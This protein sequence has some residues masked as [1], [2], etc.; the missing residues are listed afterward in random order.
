MP[1]LMR[2]QCG[3]ASSEL[4]IA[5]VAAP[6]RAANV[7]AVEAGVGAKADRLERAR[8]RLDEAGLGDVVDAALGGAP[9]EVVAGERPGPGDAAA[10]REQAEL[11][12][13]HVAHADPARAGLDAPGD[14]LPVDPVEQA[15]Q[16]VAAAAGQRDARARARDAVQRRQAGVVVAGEALHP[17]A[18]RPRRSRPRSR[19][20]RGAPRRAAAAPTERSTPAGE[21]TSRPRAASLIAA[22]CRRSRPT[23]RPGS[24]RPR[25]RCRRQRARRAALPV[26][27]APL[28]EERAQHLAGGLG[29]DAALDDRVVVQRGVAE[30]V[31]HRAGRARLRVARAVDD[32][33]DAR[34]QQRHRAHRA[35]LERHVHLALGQAVVAEQLG[36]VAQGDDLGV[37]GRVVVGDRP[38]VAGRDRPGAR[39]S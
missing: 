6:E 27:L 2:G 30:D 9:A 36:G 39:L 11:Q 21:N 19:A 34:V 7:E 22:P 33:L 18:S 16:A 15:R 13:R 4:T 29:E 31:D 23:R 20:C 3:V 35:R 5:Q 14:A 38:V 25:S 17:R 26:A 1:P 10:V 37:R 32:A 12:R 8:H 28:G 24:A